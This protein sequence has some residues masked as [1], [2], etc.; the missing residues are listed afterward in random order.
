MT[1]VERFYAL[2]LRKPIWV[3]SCFALVI[4]IALLQ[5]PKLRLDASSDSLLLQGDPDLAYFRESAEKYAGD[6]FLILT[7]EPGVPL[8]SDDSLEPL[9][10]MADELARLRGVAS[11]TTVLDVPLLESPPLSLTDLARADSIA[12]LRDP[13]VDRE[14]ALKELTTSPVYRNLLVSE[15]GDL[16][17][18][19]VSLQA[20]ELAESLLDEREALRAQEREG[21][22]DAEKAGR[23]AQVEADYDLALA[24]IG[25]ERDRMVAAVRD[26]AGRFRPYAKIFV[27]GVPMIAADM[28]A[29]VRSDLVTFGTAIL[30]V[31]AAVLWLIFR[32]WKWVF[33]P[34]ITCSATATLLLGV[35]AGTDWRMTVIS[36]NSVAVLLIVTLSLSIHL[37]VRYRE[38]QRQQPDAPREQLSAGAAKLM[39]VPCLYTA[40]TTIVAFT[41]LV[42]AGLQPVIDFGWMMTTGIVLGF[43]SAFTVVPALMVIIPDKP[44][45]T[46]GQ[47]EKP[48]TIRFARVVQQHGRLV[49][50][51]TLGLVMLSVA[52]V[53]ALEVEN[54]FIDYFKEHTE[55]YQ[56]MELL[57]ARL[58]GT[59]PLD[60]ILKAPAEEPEVAEE[61]SPSDDEGWEDDDGGFFDEVFDI[62]FGF[63]ADETQAAGY[64][65]SVPGRQ[66]ID[67][68]HAIIESRAESG[69]VLSLSTAFEVMDGLYGDKLGGVE[70]ALVENSLPEEVNNALVTPFYFAEEQEARLSV[71]VMETSES[72]RR[73]AYLRELREQILEETGIEPERLQFTSLL[74]LYNNVL[75]SLFRSQIMTLGAVFI[76]IGL[77][78]WILF[79]SLA[80]ALL[81]LAPNMLAAGLVL[82][83][84]G[85]AGIPLD[86]MTITIAAIVVGIGVDDCIHYLHRFRDE[87]AVDQNYRGAMLRSHSSIGRA[88]YYTTLTVVVGFAMLTLSNFTPSLYFGVLTV[89][90]MIAAVAGALL[91]LPQLIMIFRPFGPDHG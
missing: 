77:M 85:L 7:W 64:W 55:I 31:M 43:C 68:V 17:A 73:D 33:I 23:L 74:V 30:A 28:M 76:A 63:G 86:I 71:R 16:T 70:L 10:A 12:T 48:F 67:Q 24:R 13:D 36:S 59:I 60:V 11:V 82:G 58:G 6:E 83:L 15:R 65:F 80:L 56:G 78:F 79:R 90:A 22:L 89:V 40:M 44:L 81:A 27:G 1:R 37:V 32:S 62:D 8:L 42:V 39:M 5:L 50:A 47:A 34:L 87:I 54:R 41:S 18:V 35:L 19:Q 57:D 66:L 51:A 2:I 53:R 4:G 29:F 49:V 14:L 52:G 21:A 72:L 20:D 45:T 38:L 26:V 3:L 69:K 25:A 9:A 75:Q 61:T 91:L 84:M 88:M 46:A